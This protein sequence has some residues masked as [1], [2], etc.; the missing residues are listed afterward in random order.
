MGVVYQAED[1]HLGREVALKF[2]SAELSSDPLAFERLRREARTAS[3]INH[4]AIC[5]IFEI[6][7][8][9][10][11]TFIAMELLDGETST[12]ASIARHAH[13]RAPFSIGELPSPAR[14]RLRT[15]VASFIG[16]SSPATSLS[17]AGVTSKFWISGWPSRPIAR[18]ALTP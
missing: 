9:D 1:V 3:L 16:T 13:R 8:E 5:T 12:T 18:S 15:S 2:V 6:E 17:A 10:G 11:A 4:P 7:Q 14:L